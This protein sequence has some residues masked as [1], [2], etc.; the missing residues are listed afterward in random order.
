MLM[1]VERIPSTLFLPDYLFN[2]LQAKWSKTQ[3]QIRKKAVIMLSHDLASQ[4]VKLFIT[5]FLRT[6]IPTEWLVSLPCLLSNQYLTVPP[7]IYVSYSKHQNKRSSLGN[8][9]RG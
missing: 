1:K 8:R 7:W 5:K 2:I 3:G 4:V 9:A 6:D